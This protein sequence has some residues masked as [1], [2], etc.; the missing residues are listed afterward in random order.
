MWRVF[1]APPVEACASKE[2]RKEEWCQLN[3]N[4]PLVMNKV[5][6]KEGKMWKKIHKIW[7]CMSFQKED[8]I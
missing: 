1:S 3:Y 7:L 6:F 2:E 5:Q 4:V 8:N